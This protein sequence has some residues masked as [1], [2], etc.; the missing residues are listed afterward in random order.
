MAEYKD[1]YYDSYKK[2]D[3]NQFISEYL[4]ITKNKTCWQIGCYLGS[5]LYI[6]MGGKVAYTTKLHKRN[7]EKGTDII[8][9]RDCYWEIWHNNELIIDAWT[10]NT[11]IKEKIQCIV[12]KQFI[13]VVINKN[14][15]KFC[16]SGNYN[17]VCDFTNQNEVEDETDSIL[18]LRCENNTEYEIEVF[19]KI[20]KRVVN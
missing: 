13:D 17:L 9:V 16:F 12:N 18:Q 11:I 6:D 19:G 8:G 1:D 2:T 4:E 20:L 10:D 7:V 15:I 3:N 14:W 5:M